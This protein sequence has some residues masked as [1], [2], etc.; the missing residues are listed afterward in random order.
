[1]KSE[2][3]NAAGAGAGGVATGT[4]GAGGAVDDGASAGGSAGV[5]GITGGS[6]DTGGAGSVVQPVSRQ[7][8]PAAVQALRALYRAQ[9]AFPIRPDEGGE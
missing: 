9:N 3:R 8:R 1:M 4:D 6:D 5:A 7:S 2:R